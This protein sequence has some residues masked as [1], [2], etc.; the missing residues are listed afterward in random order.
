MRRTVYLHL[1][2]CQCRCISFW[3]YRIYIHPC[4]LVIPPSNQVKSPAFPVCLSCISHGKIRPP[5]R[6]VQFTDFAYWQKS[7]FSRGGLN[8]GHFPNPMGFSSKGGFWQKYGEKANRRT[9]RKVC[10]A[11]FPVQIWV[12][13]KGLDLEGKFCNIG[14]SKKSLTHWRTSMEWSGLEK[15]MLV[16]WWWFVQHLSYTK[17]QVCWNQISPIGLGP[18][19]LT[20]G[21]FSRHGREYSSNLQFSAW[22]F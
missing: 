2:L 9:G 20:G 4:S 11:R 17:P 13:C 16:F 15:I 21:S 8:R 10:V 6:P 19:R 22:F 5:S 1:N 14:G 18:W 3:V 12:P 7:L